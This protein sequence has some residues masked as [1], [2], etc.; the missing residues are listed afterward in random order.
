MNTRE[1]SKMSFVDLQVQWPDNFNIIEEIVPAGV[2]VK[3][4]NKVKSRLPDNAA[5]LA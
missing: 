5:P 1:A 2:A 4:K 3:N